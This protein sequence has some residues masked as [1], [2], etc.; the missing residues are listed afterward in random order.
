MRQQPVG[1]PWASHDPAQQNRN[2]IDEQLQGIGR[3]IKPAVIRYAKQTQQTSWTFA[4]TGVTGNPI[5]TI[6]DLENTGP[7]AT[8]LGAVLKAIIDHRGDDPLSN[9]GMS[10]KQVSRMR[11]IRHD[12]AHSLV[13]FSDQDYVDGALKTLGDFR[14]SINKLPQTLPRIQR[15]NQ[16]STTQRS[17]QGQPN[18][19]TQS[20]NQ[21]DG[22]KILNGI[23]DFIRRRPAAV[24]LARI[25]RWTRTEGV[26]TLEGGV[27]K[28]Q[29]R[30]PRAGI[31]VDGG[32][33]AVCRRFW[34][35]RCRPTVVVASEMAG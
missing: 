19:Q 32:L 21:P 6:K 9:I 15:G 24:A 28:L 13:D 26:R 3:E 17:N 8:A 23:V 5:R 12:H 31:R 30:W 33:A 4:V 35:R 27:R 20:T 14:Q 29:T 2:L 25:H 22:K 11:E 10:K 16:G 1:T 7:D 18:P 34:G